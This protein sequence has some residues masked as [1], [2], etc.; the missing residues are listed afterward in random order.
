VSKRA[1]K[2]SSVDDLSDLLIDVDKQVLSDWLAV[3]KSKKAGA[4]T[5]TALTAVIREAAKA[6]ISL[7]DA[8]TF[9]CELGWKGFKA[10]WYANQTNGARNT[11][12]NRHTGFTEENHYGDLKNGPVTV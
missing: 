9:S 3:R 2:S 12:T 8:I 10:T 11:L 6:G 5:R 1:S 7:N 4:L